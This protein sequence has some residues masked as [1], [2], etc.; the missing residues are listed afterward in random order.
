M[1]LR[2]FLHHWWWPVYVFV[3]PWIFWWGARSAGEALE[4]TYY[5]QALAL[6]VFLVGGLL[7]EL[8]CYPN[9]HLRDT[10][11]LPLLFLRH[12]TVALPATFGL[13]AVVAAAFSPSPIVAFMGSLYGS[14]DGAAWALGLSVIFMLV[15]AQGLRDS[16]L[17]SRIFTALLVSGFLLAG[18]AII[19]VLRDK[20]FQPHALSAPMASFGGPGHLAGMLTLV[21]AVALALWYRNNRLA[22]LTALPLTLA[23][24]LTN[25]R[26]VL[27][28]LS[29]ALFAG[30]RTPY[31]FLIAIG[32]VALGLGVGF[33]G[34]AKEPKLI[35]DLG[36]QTTF[37]TRVQL[38]KAAL[39]GVLARPIT[40]WG[41]GQFD[42]VWPRYLSNGDLQTYMG[43]EYGIK[44]VL[45]I[46]YTPSGPPA[47]LIRNK[48]GEVRAFFL[49]PWKSHNQLLEVG[50]LRGAVG[51]AIYLLLLVM[52]VRPA[53]QGNPASVGILAYLGF[54]MLWFV[55]TQVEGVM[56]VLW[57][58]ALLPQSAAQ[59][60]PQPA[61]PSV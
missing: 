43:L 36:D 26:A 5:L 28:G 47:F 59:P 19:E 9:F 34:A 33:W 35:R 8:M 32:I 49:I 61:K 18:L 41:A 57:A 24:G 50:L 37:S 17:P 20:A 54:T 21:A 48:E 31:R 56:W 38:W 55:P 12:P 6:I 1:A 15:Y 11:Y 46:S 45:N 39:G 3:C 7:L 53:W 14:G 58:V 22:L 10:I 60:M 29:L 16:R 13:W 30:W 23:I 42:E 25:R 44:E 2:V 27:I 4:F 51:L 40:G 52:L